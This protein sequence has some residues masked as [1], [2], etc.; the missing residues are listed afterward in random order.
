MKTP[1]FRAWLLGSRL[2]APPILIGTGWYVWQ[3][4]QAGGA[5]NTG[6]FALGLM[7]FSARAAYE[8]TAYRRWQANWKAMAPGGDKPRW[9]P[10]PKTIAAT[11]GLLAVAGAAIWAQD[12]DAPQLLR[13]GLLPLA[14]L[15]G[16]LAMALLLLRALH[17]RWAQWQQRR[18]ERL[19]VVTLAIRRPI[20][21][22][23]SIRACYR[24]LPP[25]CKH[26]L[27]GDN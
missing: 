25:Y 7:L 6:I 20:H 23:D 12:S 21:R 24:R 4:W 22:P 13:D 2:T 9:R 8:V 11:I 14:L 10:E 1:S 17:R 18:R 16:L 27:K 26:L 19:P 5:D 3:W 15:G